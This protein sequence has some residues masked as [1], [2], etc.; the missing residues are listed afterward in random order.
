MLDRNSGSWN[1]LTNWMRGIEE[2][3]S[4]D[5]PNGTFA[6]AVGSLTSSGLRA[7]NGSA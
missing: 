6:N 4:S 7:W 5:H 1:L 3:R 2:L